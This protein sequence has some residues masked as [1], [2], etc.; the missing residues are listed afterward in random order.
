MSW[1]V[2]HIRTTR[3]SEAFALSGDVEAAKLHLQTF[4]QQD[5]DGCDWAVANRQAEQMLDACNSEEMRQ[6]VRERID[7]ARLALS[8]GE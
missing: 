7:Q 5:N 4:V 8:L 2:S 1:R 6:A 3:M